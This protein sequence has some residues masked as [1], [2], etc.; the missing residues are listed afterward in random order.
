MASNTS[1]HTV[2]A[3]A[4][5][6]TAAER[7]QRDYA[8]QGKFTVPEPGIP[9]D[10]ADRSLHQQDAE[11]SSRRY[12]DINTGDSA[13]GHHDDDTDALFIEGKKTRENDSQHKPATPA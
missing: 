3:A 1:Q 2:I 6:E 8:Q 12:V 10:R 9:D 13:T 7:Y 5:E 4:A 11:R